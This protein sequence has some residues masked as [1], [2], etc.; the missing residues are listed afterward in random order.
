MLIRR[1]VY[2]MKRSQGLLVLF[3]VFGIVAGVAVSVYT[4]QEKVDYSDRVCSVNDTV[5]FNGSSYYNHEKNVTEIPVNRF[6]DYEE[7]VC[8]LEQ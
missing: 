3:F 7:K 8:R 6:Y 4:G 5:K 1:Q 2:S